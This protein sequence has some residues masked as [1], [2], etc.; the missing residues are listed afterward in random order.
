MNYSKKNYSLLSFNTIL[1]NGPP[2]LDKNPK[3]FQ[4]LTP[5]VTLL[6]DF[7]HFEQPFSQQNPKN[8]AIFRCY[9]Y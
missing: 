5:Q 6:V 9:E 7:T 2:L 1:G 8:F 4:K 3:T